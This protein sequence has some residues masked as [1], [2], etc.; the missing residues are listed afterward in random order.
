MCGCTKSKMKM[1]NAFA[2]IPIAEEIDDVW[3][4]NIS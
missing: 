1:P 4:W 3:L 2:G